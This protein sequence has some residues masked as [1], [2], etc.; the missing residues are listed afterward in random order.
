LLF[1]YV[2]AF[3]YEGDAPLAERRAAAL[4][5]DTTLL[6]EL[7]G[8]AELRELLE[9]EAIT[10]VERRVRW[11]TD[12]RRLRDAESVADALRVLGPLSDADLLERGGEVGWAEQLAE[13]RRAVRLRLPPGERWVAVEDLGRLRDAL[14]IPLPPG[15]SG[16][17]AEAVADPVGDLVSRFART[18]GPFDTAEA[19]ADL[20][21]GPAVVSG[22]LERLAAQGRL[23]RGAFRPGRVGS[24]WCDSD[25]L[26]QIRRASL[27]LVQRSVEPVPAERLCGFLP[28]WQEVTR[29]LRGVDGVLSVLDQLAGRA[30]PASEWERSILPS[31]V[32]DYRPELLDELTAS[33]EVLWY[34]AGAL[35]RGD[36]W[37]G[38]VPVDRAA[39]LLPDPTPLTDATPAHATLLDLL[40]DGT[41]LLTRQVE[42]ALEGSGLG[43]DA[44]DTGLWD[45][46]WAGMLTNDTLAAVRARVAA[47][48]RPTSRRVR[49]P[50]GR[51]PNRPRPGL[52]GR[53]V[54]PRSQTLMP[55]RWTRLPELRESPTLRGHATAEALLS[56]HG[57][58][59]RGAVAEEGVPGG[60]AAVYRVLATMEEAGRVR[61][62]Y[63]VEGLGAAQF[64]AGDAVDRLRTVDDTGAALVLAA[65]DPANPFGA[66]LPWPAA[67][68]THRPGRAVGASVVVDGQGLVLYL[69]RGGR[70][71][72]SW[73]PASD[74]R[75]A[76]AVSA[77]VEAVRS[78]RRP[79]VMLEKVDGEPVHGTAW[80]D[81]LVDAG[82]ATTPRGLRLR[83]PR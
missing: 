81:L 53:A 59:T 27:A 17:F 25:V 21:L 7:L 2:G 14:G 26:R 78:G 31:R 11:L 80:R 69:E 24:E 61:R 5:V 54:A 34:G 52:G 77:V 57:V 42:Q 37:L 32:V 74:P 19:A 55:G 58:V 10:A 49:P 22:T 8:Q 75:A 41:A 44:V 65:T 73:V 83:P 76:A 35:P 29:S 67:S 4:T 28:Q 45:L 60:F 63:F 18:H 79:A 30:A 50:S 82:F 16:V 38:F 56:R 33:G 12:E 23:V 36:G 72:L 15:V 71:L 13:Q 43:G 9:P 39:A 70:S 20:G 3:L 66:A 1:S 40:Q 48:G 46:V 6:A 62:G 64:A 51:Y 68:G 47:S